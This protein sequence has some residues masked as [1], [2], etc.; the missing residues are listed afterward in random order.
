MVW[1]RKPDINRALR[2]AERAL[3]PRGYSQQK[4]YDN[5]NINRIPYLLGN[6]PERERM[7]RPEAFLTAAK[8]AG[9]QHESQGARLRG[10]LRRHH[11]LSYGNRVTVQ[12]ASKTNGM[13][14][15]Y[16]Q[17]RVILVRNVVSLSFGDKYVFPASLHAGNR[18]IMSRHLS[19]RVCGHHFRMTAG[20]RTVTNLAR[21]GHLISQRKGSQAQK[22]SDAAQNP[23][24]NLHV[25]IS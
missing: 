7:A 18:T 9:Q 2:L 11:D 6:C 14:G 12:I 5:Q 3:T 22:H 25:L 15:V 1:N 17:V 16:F 13:T 21:P 8:L 4:H 19:A 10:F 20:A 23:I 24:S